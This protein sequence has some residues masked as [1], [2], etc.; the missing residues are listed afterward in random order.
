M[1]HPD[2]IISF[3]EDYNPEIIKLNINYRSSSEILSLANDVLKNS[4]AKWKELVPIL[5]SHKKK[6][7]PSKTCY[8][9]SS[10]RR[11]GSRMDS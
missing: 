1:A 8:N 3:I 10:K 6:S 7:S 2:N 4:K 5:K 11:K 9:V